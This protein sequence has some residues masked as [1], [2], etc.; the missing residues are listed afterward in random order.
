M[1]KTY[2]NIR[3]YIKKS[4]TSEEYKKDMIDYIDERSL[5]RHITILRHMLKLTQKDIAEKIGCS[6]SKISKIENSPDREISVKDLA[7]YSDALGLSM[8]IRWER[9]DTNIVDRVKYHY[10]K[11]RDSLEKILDMSKGDPKMELAA[12]K[13]SNEA[14]WNLTELMS[15]IIEKLLKFESIKIEHE[16]IMIEDL[17]SPLYNADVIKESSDKKAHT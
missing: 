16:P 12:A 5:S 1:A 8:L 17:R 6:Q 15:S 4:N 9:K 10:C 7:D 11:L 14:S 2:R 3:E 13:I